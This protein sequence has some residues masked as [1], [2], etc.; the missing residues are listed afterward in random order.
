MKY[1]KIILATIILLTAYCA[2]YS[3]IGIGGVKKISM[4]IEYVVLHTD[5]MA[6]L[7]ADV[8]QYGTKGYVVVSITSQSISTSVN[9]GNTYNQDIAFKHTFNTVKGEVIVIMQKK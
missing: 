6:T 3:Q 9:S 1:I 7:A 2:C 4:P 8:V 5:N